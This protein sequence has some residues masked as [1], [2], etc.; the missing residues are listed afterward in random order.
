MANR[1]LLVSTRS[2]R[3]WEEASLGK[4]KSGLLN[5]GTMVAFEF[6]HRNL[7]FVGCLAVWRGVCSRGLGGLVTGLGGLETGTGGL[8]KGKDTVL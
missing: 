7:V 6:P 3:L 4:V 5:M 8:L 1:V 2:C